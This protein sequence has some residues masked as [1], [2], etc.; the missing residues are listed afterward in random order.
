MGRPD[1]HQDDDSDARRHFTKRVL[2]DLGA[3]QRMHREDLFES[4]VRRIGAEQE[5]FLVDRHGRP[6]PLSPEIL[7][8]IADPHFTTEL[9]RF[10]LEVN[11]DPQDY[12]GG[13]LNRMETQV[14]QMLAK[15]RRA[16]EAIT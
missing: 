4:G 8:S 14:H 12:T 11:L 7:D 15:A 3:F 10:N 5:M 1:V 9:G 16:P 2:A 6:A 13:C